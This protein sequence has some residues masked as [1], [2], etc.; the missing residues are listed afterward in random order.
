[1]SPNITVMHTTPVIICNFKALLSAK[2]LSIHNSAFSSK[3]TSCLNQERN[4]HRS[5][6]IYKWK[7]SSFQFSESTTG[8]GL[9]HWRKHYYGLFTS[10]IFSSQETRQQLMDWICVH[11][12]WIT[13]MLLSAVWTLIL[14]APVYCRTSDV[15]LHFSKSSLMKYQTHLHLG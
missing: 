1:M 3:N 13:V 8:D 15:M 12:L 9:F 6:T 4:M 2:M 10:Q 11:Y 5:C 7:Q 14:T